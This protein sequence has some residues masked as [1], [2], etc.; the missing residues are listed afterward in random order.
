MVTELLAHIGVPFGVAF[1]VIILRAAARD[2]PIGWG[3]C[4]EMAIEMAI[5]AIWSHGGNLC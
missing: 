2:K 3:N 5:L 4:N 1:V